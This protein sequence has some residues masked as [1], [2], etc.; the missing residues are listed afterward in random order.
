MK[1]YFTL[2]GT[3]FYYGDKFLEPGMKLILEKEP[4]NKYDSEAIKV[5]IEGLGKI[6]YV[7][8]SYSTVMRECMSA[9]RIYD[10]IGDMAKAKVVLVTDKGVLCKVC[11]RSLLKSIEIIES[12]DIVE[13]S[14]EINDLFIQSDVY[15]V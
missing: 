1:V 5:S 4:D 9:G 2:T 7:A 3:Q 11:K 13:N 6:G 12:K 10:R 8:N 15:I 14:K